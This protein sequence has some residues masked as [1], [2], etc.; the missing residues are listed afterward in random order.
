MTDD[1]GHL[2]PLPDKL[3][4]HLRSLEGATI[5][6]Q[7]R[8]ALAATGNVATISRKRWFKLIAYELVPGVD[9]GGGGGVISFLYFRFVFWLYK[10]AKGR[11]CTARPPRA[12]LAASS[13]SSVSRV[14]ASTRF[15]LPPRG[16]GGRSWSHGPSRCHAYHILS[17]L[18][19]AC[20]RS[21]IYRIGMTSPR[22]AVSSISRR[23]ISLMESLWAVSMREEKVQPDQ[24]LSF[25]GKEAPVWGPSPRGAYRS[26]SG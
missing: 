15:A 5:T 2:S 20:P 21:C 7:T 14:S 13:T 26:A 16:A 24:K 18:G 23:S 4:D 9:H 12:S 6:F 11:S 17:L 8:T 10:N 3:P 19:S 25:E 1:A 22:R